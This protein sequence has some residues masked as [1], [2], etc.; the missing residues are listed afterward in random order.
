MIGAYL[1]AE[2]DAAALSAI[3]DAAIAEAGATS[4]RELGNVMNEART[5][6]AR[7]KA[8]STLAR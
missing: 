4:A 7:G 5:R 1:P 6:A 3:V 8:V 2:L